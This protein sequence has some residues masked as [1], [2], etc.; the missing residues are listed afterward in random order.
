MSTSLQLMMGLDFLTVL[1]I[2]S[3]YAYKYIV[4]WIREAYM[5]SQINKFFIYI[6]TYV[7]DF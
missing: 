7:C 2:P 6:A 5:L 1:H 4:K 3:T